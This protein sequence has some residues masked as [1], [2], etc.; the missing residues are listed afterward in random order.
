MIKEPASPVCYAAEASDA[1][2]GYLDRDA[3]IKAL[4]ELLEA[5]RAGAR[6]A[7]AS[8]KQKTHGEVQRLM[9]IVHL[10][11][12]RWCAMLQQQIKQLGGNPSPRCGA[13]HD[14]AM[15]IADPLERLSFLNRGQNWVVRRLAELL[16]RV[17]NDVLHRRLSEM[18]ESHVIGIERVNATIAL[19]HTANSRSGTYPSIRPRG[20]TAQDSQTPIA[21]G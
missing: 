6:V 8:Q 21:K 17:R 12:A 18:Q 15:K 1:Y 14:K 9:N 7:L 10:D 20:D 13:F 4:N 19:C 3:L 11:E 2:M 5:E 16:P